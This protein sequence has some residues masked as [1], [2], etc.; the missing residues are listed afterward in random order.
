MKTVRDF[1]RKHALLILSAF[2]VLSVPAGVTFGKYVQSVT[3]TDTL[4]LNVSM[5]T[6]TLS[7]AVW[8]KLYQSGNTFPAGVNLVLDYSAP[9]GTKQ[10]KNGNT[11]ID[12]SDKTADKT[13]GPIYACYDSASNTIYVVPET[14]GR[15]VA[16]NCKMMFSAYWDSSYRNILKS[17]VINNLDTSQVQSMEEMFSYNHGLESVILGADSG[18]S[19]S[20][21]TTMKKMFAWCNAV[22]AL[23]LTSFR[24]SRVTDMTYMFWSCK[25]LTNIAG[26]RQFD[27]SQVTTMPCMFCDCSSMTSLDLST[28]NTSH[29]TDMSGMFAIMKSLQ[30]I[31]VSDIFDVS[32]VTNSTNMF[33]DCSRLKGGAGTAYDGNYTDKTYAHIDGGTSAPG[34][35]TAAHGTSTRSTF[36]ATGTDAQANGFGLALDAAS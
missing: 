22:T 28:F 16:A 17:I 35:F 12:L 4:N 21:V 6:Y 29:V 18:F 32:N 26:L 25:K 36:S 3:V 9:A 8:Q 15:M 20:N 1:L 33:L 23:D 30:T 11:D 27:T 34:Y 2:V 19:T 31:T 10:L 7:E 5:K 13:T 24:T 14:P